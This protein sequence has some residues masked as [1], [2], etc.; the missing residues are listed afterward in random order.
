M[1]IKSRQVAGVTTLV[2][3]IVSALSSYHLA[4]LARLSLQES[5]SRGELLRHAIS[6]RAG[7]VPLGADPYTALREDG[8]I[9]SIL[10][11]SV[12]YSPNVVYAAIVNNDGIAVAHAFP[13]EEGKAIPELE[14]LTT[15]LDRNAFALLRIVNSD[16]TFEMRQP[17]LFGDRQFGAIR[18][19][20]STIL[21]KNELRQAF[22]SAM[23][24]ILLALVVSML[25]AMALAQW[26]LRP[27]HVIQSGLTRL[28]RGELDVRLDL[29]EG[30]EFKDLGS[31]FDAVSA[32]LS[33]SRAKALSSPTD[34]ESVVDNLADAVALFGPDGKLMF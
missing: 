19:G 12:G 18:I 9:R 32:Q 11:S 20:I 10:Q 14:D 27:I 31:S 7:E 15:I 5:A 33:E 1:S 29:P 34:F 2:V 28:G 21:V 17:L 13:T 26:M 4:T 22:R 25:V 24:N 16:R 3:V 23:R 30:H 6:Q 8:G